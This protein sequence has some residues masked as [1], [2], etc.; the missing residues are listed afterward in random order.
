[1]APDHRKANFNPNSGADQ[2]SKASSERVNPVNPNG[3]KP[4]ANGSQTKHEGTT[5]TS[6]AIRRLNDQRCVSDFQAA[7]FARIKGISGSHLGGGTGQSGGETLPGLRSPGGQDPMADLIIR[8]SRVGVG[9]FSVMDNHLH[10]LVRLNPAT[11]EAW[12]DDEVIRRWG[13]LFPP[14]G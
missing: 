12:S 5:R 3:A 6:N 9:G 4:K 8:G 2:S 10:V 1:M 14:C 11:A 13:R 7:V